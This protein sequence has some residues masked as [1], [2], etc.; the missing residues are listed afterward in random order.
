MKRLWRQKLVARPLSL[1]RRAQ[2]PRARHVQRS[3]PAARSR[4]GT[5][6]REARRALDVGRLAPDHRDADL[7][8]GADHRRRPCSR[9]RAPGRSRRRS[10]RA[11]RRA[12]SSTPAPKIG[13]SNIVADRAAVAAHQLEGLGV[14]G[15]DAEVLAIAGRDELLE[16]AGLA[17][18]RLDARADLLGGLL[19][20]R[21]EERLLVGEV[22]V[23]RPARELACGGRRRA[24]SRRRSR[25]RRTRPRAAARIAARLAAFVA[26]R[27][28]PRR[29]RP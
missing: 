28:P 19:E 4:R 13:S 16:R 20:D 29:L 3:S 9:D 14:G 27:R 6:R 22:V 18:R 12:S 8:R 21:A 25:A 23:E 7:E 11:G 24:P 5:P 10:R 15:E 17:A 1:C 2:R 26:A